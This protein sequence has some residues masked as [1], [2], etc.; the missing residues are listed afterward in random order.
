MKRFYYLMLLFTLFKLPVFAQTTF[1]TE[2]FVP[3]QG[4]TV[5][6][7]WII[8]NGT[9][10]FSWSPQIENFD[11]SAISPVI[12]LHES[13]SKLIVTQFLDIFSMSS[14]EI[15]EVSIIHE[16]GEDIIW[17][18]ALS[19]GNWGTI[20][21]DELEI[22]IGDYAGLDVQFKFRTYGASTFNWNGWYIFEFSLYADLDK[23]LAVMNI[24]GPKKL[25]IGELGNWGVTV[26]NTGYQAVSDYSVKLFNYKTGDLIASFDDTEQIEPLA[27]KFYPFNWSSPAAYNTALY[28]VIVFEDD[29]FD[30][31][32]TSMS[33]YIRIEPDIDY[34]VM[35]WDND[36]D[37]STIICPEQ[38]N[39]IQPSTAL[40]RALDLAGIDY[41]FY[42]YLPGNLPDFDIIFSTM[43][44]FCLS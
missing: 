40:T 19:E 22:P 32:N 41:S 26:K 21:G 15:A 28:S 1:L 44:C 18:Y 43:G 6:G 30:G 13:S 7:N 27:S 16:N 38:G 23:D 39:L 20:E 4:W 36:N 11:C 33:H 10:S 29:E 2:D 8:D 24:T 14:D 5:E 3:G 31:N 34:N 37:I 35:V 9:M 42:K 12:S 25:N 17:S